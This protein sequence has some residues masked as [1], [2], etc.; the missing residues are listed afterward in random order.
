[1]TDNDTP[2][3]TRAATGHGFTAF[4][5]GTRL[6]DRY[7]IDHVMVQGGFGITYGGRHEGLNRIVAIQEHF[8]RQF[9]YRD[10][11]TS[12]VRP[13]DPGTYAWA[14]DRF[15][16]EGR[17]HATC[18]LTASAAMRGGEQRGERTSSL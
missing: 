6:S 15:L 13:S 9:A 16:A 11:T 14:L 1:M 5:L 3:D 7:V 17:A 4:S 10:G 18:K 8:P 12:E 2:G